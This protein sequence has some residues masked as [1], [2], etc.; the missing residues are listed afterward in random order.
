MKSS[1]T[2]I[3]QHKHMCLLHMPAEHTVDSVLGH[4][5]LQLHT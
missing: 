1:L 5:I 2:L 3:L 4:C